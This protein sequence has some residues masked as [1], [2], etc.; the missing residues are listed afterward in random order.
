MF[1]F[2]QLEC[3]EGNGCSRN[4]GVLAEQED[5]QSEAK[6]A[7]DGTQLVFK[8]TDTYSIQFPLHKR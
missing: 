5:V 7:S 1:C 3:R 6:T 4:F 2:V 8:W